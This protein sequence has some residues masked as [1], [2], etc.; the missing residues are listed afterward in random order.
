METTESTPL[1]LEKR[2]RG[3]LHQREPTYGLR[4]TEPETPEGK[5]VKDR[6]PPLF[7]IHENVVPVLYEACKYIG[8]APDCDPIGGRCQKAYL[9]GE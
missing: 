3:T 1:L 4:G 8:I 5:N 9:R 2:C 7:G 6:D